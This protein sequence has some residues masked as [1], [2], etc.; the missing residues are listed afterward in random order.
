MNDTPDRLKEIQTELAKILEARLA[1]LTDTLRSTEGVTRRLVAAEIEIERHR[2]ARAQLEK[3]LEGLQAEVSVLSTR[4][5]DANLQRK[6]LGAEREGLALQVESAEREVRETDAEAS[7]M[8]SRLGT[9]NEEADALRVETGNLKLKLKTMEENITRMRRLKEELMS[10]IS[11][12][13]AQM[14]GLAGSG[15][16]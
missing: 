11:G 13:T 15:A 4:A 10:S 7:K 1:E 8:R 3:E 5:A 12:L 6:R 2:G 14:S 16:E 9:L